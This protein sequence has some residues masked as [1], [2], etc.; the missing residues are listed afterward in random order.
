MCDPTGGWATAAIAGTVLKAGSDIAGGIGDRQML[1]AQ[2]LADDQQ[3]KS[4]LMASAERARRIHMQGQRFLAE[5]RVAY[6]NSGV[7]GGSGSALEV[8]K[9]DAA[10]IEL[11]MLTEMY[12][13][14]SR[15]RALRT[16]ASLKRK[17]GVAAQAAG[18]ARGVSSIL[19][20]AETW[21][22]LGGGPGWTG[23]SS[24][25]AS[26]PGSSGKATRGG[27]ARYVR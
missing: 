13:G 7:E 5:Q 19:Q 23:T 17:Q 2:A 20:S 14:T 1:S 26:S 9:A 3:A 15:A 16:E 6:A 18:V 24:S 12:G 25:N 4:E 10:E 22:S 21:G 11:D 8:G 27:M